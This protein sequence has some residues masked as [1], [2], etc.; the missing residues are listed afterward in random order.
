MK[1]VLLIYTELLDYRIPIFQRL[2]SICELTVTHSGAKATND[3]AGFCEIILPVRKI[4]RFR[5]QSKVI[6]LIRSGKFHTIIFFGDIAWL[7]SLIGFF[8]CPAR[9]RRVTWGFWLTSKWAANRLRLTMAKI[10][11]SNIFY[12]DGAASA[13]RQLGTPGDRIEIARNTV[14]VP[15]PQ[16][17][18]NSER[19]SILVIG[20]FNLRKQNDVVILAFNAIAKRLERP[21]RLVFVGGGSD[22]NRI[23][24]LS[25]AHEFS[26]RIEFHPYEVDTK[27]L[28][29]YYSKAICS[30]SFG[31]A[32]LSVLQSFGYGVP[33][34][35]MRNAISGGEIENISHGVNG[36]LCEPNQSSL[37]YYL[38]KLCSDVEYSAKLGQ[39]ALRFY[40]N[41]ASVAAM[42]SGFQ[43]AID[44]RQVHD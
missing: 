30:V 15:D 43:R 7:S 22:R 4:W 40:L 42:I 25:R 14:L 35:T 32:G 18:K 13:F 9:T 31:Q 3:D 33:F 27:A 1:K 20:A 8:V 21:I 5:Y 24:E 19:D 26:E 17:D 6:N 44:S 41:H 16:R 23:I 38:L 2:A 34:V 12:N 29:D 37:E 39:N 36:F 28:R 10:S 11:D